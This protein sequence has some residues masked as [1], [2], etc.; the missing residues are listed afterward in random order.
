MAEITMKK[1]F[2]KQFHHFLKYNWNKYSTVTKKWK[3]ILQKKETLRGEEN[4]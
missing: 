2:C 3:N 1:V 4:R